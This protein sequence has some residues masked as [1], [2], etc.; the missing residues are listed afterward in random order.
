MSITTDAALAHL[1]CAYNQRAAS[2]DAIIIGHIRSTI[3]ALSGERHTHKA[4]SDDSCDHC[5]LDLRNEIHSR[6][7]SPLSPPAGL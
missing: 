6:V 7:G 3:I 1:R 4:S 5:G 2:D